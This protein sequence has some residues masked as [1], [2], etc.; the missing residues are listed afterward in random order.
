MTKD[1]AGVPRP[2]RL[3]CTYSG[4]LV[5]YAAAKRAIGQHGREGAVLLFADTRMEDEDLYRFLRESAEHLGVPLVTVADGRDPWQVFVDERFIGNSR[6]DPC[7][8]KLKRELMDRWRAEHCD[9]A[10]TVCVYGLDW[11]ERH[12]IE[13]NA[14]KKGHR[15]RQREQGWRAEYPMNERP[16]L[17][18]DEIIAD[19]RSVGI[20]PPRL[21]A[22]GYPHNNC[23]GW[24]CKMGHAQARHLLRTLPDRYRWH[25]GR[26][27]DAMAAIGP[28]A[29]PFLRTRVG[30][31]TRGVTMREFRELCESLPLLDGIAE[32]DGWGCG[33][34]CA[35]DDEEE[36]T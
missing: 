18:K 24:C 1:D 14:A 35:V 12:R 6:V 19:L 10:S 17:T 21:Y 33:G 9:Q 25:E 2:V 22:M 15:A 20:E 11:S 23:G 28:T 30:G 8:K 27:A 5:S 3:L 32:E 4:G 13:G 26:E 34:G 36:G 7:S 16:Y 29:R 31:V